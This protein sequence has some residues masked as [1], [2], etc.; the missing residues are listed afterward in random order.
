[1][2]DTTVSLYYGEGGKSPIDEN[3][4]R[5]R[6]AEMKRWLKE[7]NVKYSF[8]FYPNWAQVPISVDLASADA[9]MFKLRFGL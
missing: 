4:T 2:L 3:A 8:T 6:F 1:M 9:V 5:A 7:N